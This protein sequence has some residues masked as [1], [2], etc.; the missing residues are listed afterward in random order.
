METFNK[1]VHLTNDAI[2]S[3]SSDYG[4]FQEGNKVSWKNFQ[5]WLEAQGYP[6]FWSQFTI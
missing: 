3:R 2:Q 4:K 6:R 1:F 5:K